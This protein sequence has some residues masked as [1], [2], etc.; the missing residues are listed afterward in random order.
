MKYLQYCREI[1]NGNFV[2]LIYRLSLVSM[3]EF[4]RN[5]YV[6]QIYAEEVGECKRCK[7]KVTQFDLNSW[8]PFKLC[9]EKFL[10]CYFPNKLTRFPSFS[11]S[12][13][14]SLRAREKINN[15]V[16]SELKS[17]KGEKSKAERT[18]NDLLLWKVEIIRFCRVLY[19]KKLFTFFPRLL[20]R[21]P[22]F[23]ISTFLSVE[24]W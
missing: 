8:S 1:G 3:G 7:E 22:L 15:S 18:T 14:C 16:R 21:F 17:W 2:D 10:S 24:F 6:V 4:L 23:P 19:G 13:A 20:F 12:H 11:H 9:N 5:L